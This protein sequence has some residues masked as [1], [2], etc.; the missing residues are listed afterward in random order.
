M[1]EQHTHEVPPGWLPPAAPDPP[2]DRPSA[3]GEPQRPWWRRAGGGL[4]ATLVVIGAKL[5]AILLLLP[6]IKVLT[7]SGSM[8]VSVAAYALIWGWK[9]AVGFVVLLFI[10]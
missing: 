7:T 2:A 9:F 6:K 5:K 8:L 1:S 4:I 3:F 10:H